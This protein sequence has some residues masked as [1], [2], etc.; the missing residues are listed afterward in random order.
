M[1]FIDLDGFKPINDQYGHHIGDVLLIQVADRLRAGL[2][3]SDMV[4]R[5]GGDEFIVLSESANTIDAAIAL[6]NKILRSLAI[7]YAIEGNRITIGSSI[8]VK[9]IN[10]E[11]EHLAADQILVDAD[12][13]MYQAKTNRN[14]VVVYSASPPFTEMHQRSANRTSSIR[15]W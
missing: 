4:F 1:L 5:W 10:C 8:G 12:V 9:P 3:A 11:L 14:C 7:A 15:R 2:R 13:A 6:G